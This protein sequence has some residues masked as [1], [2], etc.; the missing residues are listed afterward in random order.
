MAEG[1]D[2]LS[3][4]DGSDA[5]VV[6]TCTPC[7]EEGTSE[8]AVKYCPECDEYLCTT[9]TKYHRKVKTSRDHKLVDR[10]EG[11]HKPKVTMIT[12]KIKCRHHP[13]REIEMYCG[14]HDMVYCLMC[15]AT[16]HRTCTDVT[17][18]T[19]AAGS[20]IQHNEIDRLQGESE[21]IK[22]LLVS[23]EKTKQENVVLLKE[24]RK[25]IQRRIQE[26]E[27]G[28]IEHIKTLSKQ[29]NVALDETCAK[30]NA[31]LETYIVL[32]DRRKSE[33]EKVNEQ[34]QSKTEVNQEQLFVKVKLCQH[35]INEAKDVYAKLESRGQVSVEFEESTNVKEQFLEVKSLG[36]MQQSCVNRKR[37]I[38]RQKEVN[39]KMQNDQHTCWIVDICQ[40][41]SGCFILADLFNKKVK[42]MEID[43][44]VTDHFSVQGQ[45]TG[46]CKISNNEVA[47]KLNTNNLELLSI[48]SY[49]SK[50]RSISITQGLY[51]GMTYTNG[52]F[53]VGTSSSVDAYDINGTFEKRVALNTVGLTYTPKQ[54]TVFQNSVFAADE[55]NGIVCFKSNGTKQAEFRDS[56][57]KKTKGVC[58]L[59]DGTVC[60][61]D[62]ISK[63][64]VMFSENGK[65]LGELVPSVPSEKIPESLCYDDKNNCILIGYYNSDTVT[66][67]YLSD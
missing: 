59:C 51:R 52:K 46:I 7:S 65:C 62:K 3:I 23:M 45:P 37:E 9:C 17:S 12:K 48:G 40:L 61:I 50:L 55:S 24:K 54:M 53:W 34:L 36:K 10:E 19:D 57:L 21:T 64:I 42:L 27:D 26:I 47:V 28:M 6:F 5:Y 32:V 67:L 29:A 8:E 31:D 4:Q 22:E 18:L 13:D 35:I 38:Q 16:D 11:K 14:A 60:T 1:E 39:L 66:V 30:V 20:D 41:D 56:R 25:Q 43:H 33:V 44:N 63:K 2:H 58:I 49:I 15:I